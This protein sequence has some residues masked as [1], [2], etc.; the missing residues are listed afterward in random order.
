L[1]GCTDPR[2]VEVSRTHT[3]GMSH[4]YGIGTRGFP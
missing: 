1:T 3:H 2:I 4:E